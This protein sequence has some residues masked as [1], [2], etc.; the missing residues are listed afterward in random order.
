MYEDSSRAI[1]LC[2]TYFKAYLRKGE[3]SVELGKLPK[4][5]DT[6]LIDQGIE[7]LQKALS[8]CWKLSPGDARY[9]QKAVFEKQ[10]SKQI[11][12]AKKIRWFK[13]KE[14]ERTDR[15]IILSQL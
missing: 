6:K 4:Y 11:L 2:P 13:Q 7:T 3:A 9:S 14:V 10:I 15:E 1:E 12:K 5:V 8:I